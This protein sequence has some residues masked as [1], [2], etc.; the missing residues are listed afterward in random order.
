MIQLRPQ[1]QFI[2]ISLRG[3]TFC[4]T[5]TFLEVHNTTPNQTQTTT[6]FSFNKATRGPPQIRTRQAGCL[7]LVGALCALFE[8]YILQYV[9]NHD[10]LMEHAETI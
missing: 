1:A 9:L 8:Q 2:Y 7:G 5:I 10:S 3:V 6:L 4:M